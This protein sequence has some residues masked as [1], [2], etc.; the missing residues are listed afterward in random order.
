MVALIRRDYAIT[1]AYPLALTFDVF[2]GLI[3][4]LIFFFISRTFG[5]MASADLHGAPTYF[6]FVVVGIVITLVVSAAS[7][8]VGYRL[9]QEQVTGT[10]EALVT[11][12]VRST[13]IAFGL[14]G[15][16]FGLALVRGF[17]YLLVSWAAFG[18][19]LSRASWAGCILVLAA[20]GLALLGVGI[21]LGAAVVV[22]KRGQS[23]IGLATTGLAFL[24]GAFFPAQILPHWLEV[25]GTLVPTRYVYD[26]VR[27]ALFQGRGWGDDAIVLLAF[28]VVGLPI[29]LWVFSRALAFVKRTGSLGQY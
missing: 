1:R 3:D 6:A 26:G 12:P 19:D 2:F 4:V 15:F 11:Q 29:A 27:A 7:A 13:Q 18:L 10:L 24:S 28:S 17:V 14:A 9:Q 21:V 20:S 16:P 8:E 22:L 5:D 23:L 25:I